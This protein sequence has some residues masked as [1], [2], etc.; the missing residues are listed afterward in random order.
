MTTV[1]SVTIGYGDTGTLG[2]LRAMVDLVNA[3]LTVPA[4]VFAARALAVNSAPARNQYRQAIGIRSWLAR[5]FKFVDDPTGLELLRDPENLLREYYATNR[6][7]GDCD[8]A[9]VLGAA[10]GK[11]IGLVAC[12]TVYAFTA[13]DG[14]SGDF[15][16]VFASLLTD[17]G[18]AVSLDV[19]K[20]A[21]SVPPPSRVLS[22]E[23]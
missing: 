13:A 9:A 17:D 22:V 2:D 3:S 6:I 4:V 21:G 14:G 5:Y 11:A 16:H 15:S 19:T 10:L 18:R 20:P 8:E 12:F 7:I 23:V 1:S